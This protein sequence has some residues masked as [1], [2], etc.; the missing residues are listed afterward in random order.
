MTK[1]VALF[2]RLAA[3]EPV[4]EGLESKLSGPPFPSC[5]LPASLPLVDLEVAFVLLVGLGKD[6]GAVSAA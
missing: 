3:P 6:V 4:E 5:R 2:H 1:E